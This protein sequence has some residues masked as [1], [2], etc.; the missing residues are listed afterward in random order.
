MN[1]L[2]INNKYNVTVLESSSAFQRAIGFFSGTK[3]SFETL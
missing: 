1:C 3:V 2:I